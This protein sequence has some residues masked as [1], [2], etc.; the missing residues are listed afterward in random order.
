MG[1]NG[2]GYKADLYSSRNLIT[3]H[4]NDGIR[5]AMKTNPV[6]DRL[7]LVNKDDPTKSLEL[8]AKTGDDG[9]AHLI[10]A[11]KAPEAD[12][13]VKKNHKPRIMEQAVITTHQVQAVPADK[14]EQMDKMDQ[15]LITV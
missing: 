7:T 4:D 9:K 8:Y 6:F 1:E 3:Y 11:E 12:N 15:M 10:Q 5:I 14:M 13:A 2:V